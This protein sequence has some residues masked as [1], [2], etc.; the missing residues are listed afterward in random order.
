[1]LIKVL[2]HARWVPRLLKPHEQE[3]RVHESMKLLRRWRV[4]D[5]ALLD[6]VITMDET[7]LLLQDPET[8]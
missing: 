6:N 1:M 4:Q 3:K 2:V 5:D 8:R 7:W